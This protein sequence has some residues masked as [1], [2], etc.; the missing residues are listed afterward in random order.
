[1][2]Q[3]YAFEALNRT[4]GMKAAEKGS[5]EAYM[6]FL[7]ANIIRDYKRQTIGNSTSMHK[8]LTVVGPL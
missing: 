2:T 6:C 1:M 3:R 7:E 8:Q 5:L 4:L